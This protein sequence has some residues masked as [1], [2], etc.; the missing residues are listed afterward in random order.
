MFVED[1]RKII[2]SEKNL[3]EKVEKLVEKTKKIEYELKNLK[4]KVKEKNLCVA[5]VRVECVYYYRKFQELVCVFP[6][7]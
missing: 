5:I 6:F 2:N 4:A 7:F 1:M 3:M